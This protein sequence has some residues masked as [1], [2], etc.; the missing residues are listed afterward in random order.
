MAKSEALPDTQSRVARHT[1]ERINEHLR[2][3]MEARVFYLAHSPERIDARLAELDREWD[4]DRV[5]ETNAAGVSLFGVLM[6]RRK[7][8][9]LVLPCAVAGFLIQHAIQGWCPPVP[10][11]RRLGFRTAREIDDER[12]ALRVLK[13]DF[14]DI[15][16]SSLKDPRTKA[17]KALAAATRNGA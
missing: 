9:W 2:Q 15:D 6:A 17:E 11:F 12:Y 14:D 7:R 4:I 8:K 5:L 10:V 3:E 16:V 1:D 13:G